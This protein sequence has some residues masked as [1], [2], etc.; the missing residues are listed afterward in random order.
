MTRAADAGHVAVV[1]NDGLAK[2]VAEITSQGRFGLDTEFLRERT[3]KPKLCLVQ[4]S[5]ENKVFVIDPLERV[6]LE[7][8]AGPIGSHDVEVL[9]HAG[10]QD[11]ELFHEAFGVVPSCVFDVQ[12]AAGFAGHGA[13]LSYGRL[14]ESVLGVALE[15]GESYTDW[16]RRPL[17]EKQL[18]Y[19]AD[20]V[21]YLIPAAEELQAELDEQGR[22][23]WAR[24]ELRQFE[25]PEAYVLDPDEMWRK[26][27][28]RGTLS[29]RQTSVLRELAAWR[30]ETAIRRDI[31]RGWV[32]K[33]P[34]LIEIA[35]RLPSSPSALR[36]IRGMN[37][38][39]AE[40][41]GRE[42][43]AAVER[44][45]QGPAVEKTR[46]P[47]RSVQARARMLSGLA[48]AI[49][50]ARCEAA[51]IATELVV[52][53]GEVELLMIDLFSL[54]GDDVEA[55]TEANHRVLQ[56]WRRELAGDAILALAGGRIGVRAI[57][58]PPYVQ[59][60]ELHG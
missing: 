50:R 21:R 59:E 32:V 47:S 30:E 27:G 19:A 9:V 17:T 38:K 29:G 54:R 8:L 15:K 2:C 26:V 31:P 28:G 25:R 7:P 14:V 35:R 60:V 57:D 13:S 34:T 4:V 56:G 48:D 43:L 40:K 36:D 49:V 12:V 51:G 58:E 37:A 39:E 5:T 22:L 33:D 20:D 11:L 16:C 53:R 1:D 3:Y 42:I 23:G 41:S 6:D 52:T 55:K 45:K 18:T 44:G 46:P 24:E 10:R